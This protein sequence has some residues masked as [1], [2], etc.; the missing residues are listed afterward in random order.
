M[1]STSTNGTSEGLLFSRRISEHRAAVILAV[2]VTLSLASLMTRM[3]G[4]AIRNGIQGAVSVTMR[5]FLKGFR[6]F[7]DAFDYATGIVFAYDAARDEARTAQ[8]R[9]ADL[10]ER[11]AQHNEQAAENKRLRHMLNFVRNQPRL[12]LE[13]VEVLQRY[14]GIAM[15]DRG[16]PDGIQEWMCAMTE[17]GI[18]GTVTQVDLTVSYV[19]TL[20]N[21]DCRIGAMIQRNR[22][23]GMVHGRGNDLSRYC[24]MNYIDMKDD[25]REGDLVVTSPESAFPA[26]YPIGRVVDVD[27][28]GTLWKIAYVEPAVDIYRLDEVFVLR[29]AATPF[30]DLAA[31]FASGKPSVAPTTPDKR[32]IQ[33]RYAP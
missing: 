22:V 8:Q 33:E 3:Q 19:V 4:T 18:V 9:V 25:V 15:I 14:N 21:P 30:A 11:L 2:L 28:T 24:T 17:D 1:T 29:Q 31:P 10:M 7:Q 20:H 5:P 23:R 32:S 27:D 26:G 6:G 13:A 16:A 12:T